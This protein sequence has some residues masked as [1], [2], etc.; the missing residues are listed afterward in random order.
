V[1]T[2]ASIPLIRLQVRCRADQECRSTGVQRVRLCDAV[3]LLLVLVCNLG[4]KYLHVRIAKVRQHVENFSLV[5]GRV[6]NTLD[7]EK[8]ENSIVSDYVLKR[9]V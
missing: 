3:L 7:V 4:H 1:G 2:E 8:I 5:E 9:A 6:E